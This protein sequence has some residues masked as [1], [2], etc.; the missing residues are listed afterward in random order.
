MLYFGSNDMKKSKYIGFSAIV[1][2]FSRQIA[3]Y[4]PV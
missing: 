4:I 2:Q 1:A 3:K